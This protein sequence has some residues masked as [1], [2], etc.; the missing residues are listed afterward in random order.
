MK[1]NYYVALIVL[2]L[3]L[4]ALAA[5]TSGASTTAA[6]SEPTNAPQ[7]ATATS[8]PLPV[9]ASALATTPAR[10][11]NANPPPAV[12]TSTAT[13]IVAT[14]T[15]NPTPT[16]PPLGTAG[17]PI[18]LLF[19]P[20]AGSVVI[21]QRAEPLAEALRAATG[22][23]FAV[24]VVD[25]EAAL[26]ELLCAAPE[27]AIGFLSAAAYVI[28]HEQCDARAGLVARGVDG[29]PWEMG[30]LVIRPGTAA[31]LTELDGK[32]WAAADTRSM[33]SYLY[34]KAQMTAAG[35]EPA[36]IVDAPEEST[37]L[38]ALHGGRA[39]F[40]TATYVPP[41]MPHGDVWVYGQHEAEVWRLLGI[42]PS[43]SP[44]GYVI[45]AAEPEFG[46]YRLR[47]ARARLF[48][49]T[50]DIFNV[51][52]IL[53]IS[54]PIP[55]ETVVFGVDLPLDLAQQ[56]EEIMTGFAASDV[57]N[58]SL[59]SADLFGWT[60]LEPIDDSAYEPIRNIKD[61]LGLEAADLW[62]ELD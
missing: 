29:L 31:G 4:G 57:C 19:P 22:A 53:A 42:Q 16:R 30:M 27:D 6:T 8:Q 3:S 10:Q 13:P 48:D 39:D 23:S 28:A 7:V 34:F 11:T 46:G 33:A 35:I 21:M 40:T 1:R 51:T 9:A 37:A 55:N 24:G 14:S 12:A 18:Q 36:G 25:S 60:G 43:R 32:L 50:P 5:C 47:D 61:T 56:V 38:L 45:V 26:V 49:T 58:V 54:E 44:I 41:V 2:A 20:V 59:C 52:R 62:A 15:P 17:R